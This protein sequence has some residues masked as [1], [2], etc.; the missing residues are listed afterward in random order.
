MPANH[1]AV[2]A[3]ALCTCSLAL[4]LSSPPGVS[5]DQS[6]PG[7]RFC[8]DAAVQV[9]S[10]GTPTGS[11]SH[12][13]A[14]P[15]FDTTRNVDRW[16]IEMM[17]PHHQSIIAMAQAALPR[18][19]DA[20]LLRIAEAIVETQQDEI[21]RL[22]DLRSTAIAGDPSHTPAMA[23][24]AASP[25][26]HRAQ[27]HEPS[28]DP[29]ILMDAEALVAEFCSRPYPDLAFIAL[30]VPHHQMAIDAS[31]RVLAEGT[32]PQVKEIARKV[33]AAQQHEIDELTAIGAELAPFATPVSTAMHP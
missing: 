20:R 11:E 17:I 7:P 12:A 15:S 3:I 14:I 9:H 4:L 31:Q 16:Y 8:D 25:P 32:D 30:S 26:A 27:G 6:S 28:D 29:A 24:P 1:T 23:A 5:A 2:R 13:P 19:D 18:L 22:A 21:D 10:I 33:I